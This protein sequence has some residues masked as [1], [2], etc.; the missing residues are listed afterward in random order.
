MNPKKAVGE[1]A[2]EF[3]RDGMVVGLGTGSTAQF[4]VEAM[5]KRVQDEQLHIRCVS[6]SSVTEKLAK[7]LGLNM[8]TL[9][10]VDE[11]DLT[12]DGADEV[13]PEFYGIKGG[14]GALLLE[15]IVASHSKEN[16]WIVDDS[17]VVEQLGA[18][19]LPIEVVPF[20]SEH[21]FSM[22]EEKGYAPAFRTAQEGTKFITDSKHYI[23]DLHL[24]KI[25]D[26]RALA[27]ELKLEIGV[28]EHGLF[29]DSTDIVIVG[30]TIGEVKILKK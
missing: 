18:F 28:V 19:P 1:K 8:V 21:L 7:E 13:S 5:A 27:Q 29:I 16:I 24:N 10:D 4:M 22:F 17:K 3:I 14:G 25:D 11:I 23:I 26:P 12:I 30:N 20:G 2:A 9:A 15:K 6:T